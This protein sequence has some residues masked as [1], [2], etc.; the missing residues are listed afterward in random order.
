MGLLGD[1]AGHL[2]HDIAWREGEWS[3]GFE[4]VTSIRRLGSF[5]LYATH[6]MGRPC[7]V[8]VSAPNVDPERAAA[9]AARAIAAHT[10]VR[11][12]AIPRVVAAGRANDAV[13]VAFD[14]PARHD[15]SQV[16]LT[17]TPSQPTSGEVAG[18]LDWLLGIVE[19]FPPTWALHRVG[20]SNLLLDDDGQPWVVG[21]GS[22][23]LSLQGPAL[24]TVSVPEGSPRRAL[25]RALLR[26][27][28]TW[29]GDGAWWPAVGR[30]DLQGDL[31]D[32]SG[33]R[34]LIHDGWRLDGLRPDPE[35]LQARLR[36]AIAGQTPLGQAGTRVG[37][38]Y[39][40]ERRLGFS[41]TGT[42]FLARDEALDEPVVLRGLPDDS[43]E[44]PR[45]MREVRLLRRL[46][47]PNMVGGFDLVPRDGG[48]WVIMAY[49]PGE[50]L[51]AHID[52]R[53]D[54]VR[55][56]ESLIGIADALD[57]LA[58]QGIVHRNVTP[59]TVLV[60][61]DRGAVL[62]DFELARPADR[63]AA[64]ARITATGEVLG[65]FRY[66]APEVLLGTGDLTP[67]VDIY[68]LGTVLLEVFLGRS[69]PMHPGP[70][71]A[72]RLLAKTAAPG[73]LVEAIAAA[74]A[75]DPQA[76]PTAT[77]LRE[78]LA[79][80]TSHQLCLTPEGRQVQLDGVAVAFG[81]RRAHPRILAA[82][83]QRRSD[84]DDTPM[85]VADLI[86]VGWPGETGQE[87]SFRNRV[88]VTLN[89]LRELGLGS[90]IETVGGGYRLARAVEVRWLPGEP[91]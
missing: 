10:Q 91:S 74:L 33:L 81:R 25:V 11:H 7:L 41:P 82:M 35:G 60:D 22:D 76:R 29:F 62:V 20:I 43:P 85:S 39:R 31:E 19:V 80:P 21:L 38:R 32:L 45:L 61:P 8:A 78:L 48:L 84:G 47:H 6:R 64:D 53:D 55:L 2:M 3:D 36:Q 66:L 26:S 46:R 5:H 51:A 71:G 88:Y 27:G 17:G 68:A 37:G 86:G 63:G 16:L 67:A 40:I 65:A 14:C 34:S 70:S 49:V 12:P 58:S 18:L 87:A 50:S 73:A 15:V 13:Y 28:Y 4:A 1:G 42:L 9:R 89:S 75:E 90:V 52:Q 72:R 59:Q 44:A 56:T 54:P 24:P 77:A 23:L 57:A 69:C 30:G 83:A 79:T